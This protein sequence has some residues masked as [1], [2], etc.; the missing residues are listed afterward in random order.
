MNQVTDFSCENSPQDPESIQRPV[1]AES[2]NPCSL[3]LCLPVS[4]PTSLILCSVDGTVFVSDAL[5]PTVT[6]NYRDFSLAELGS[7]ILLCC[8]CPFLSPRSY[9]LQSP[10]PPH[11]SVSKS[12]T[13]LSGQFTLKDAAATC[14]QAGTYTPLPVLR[15]S[16]IELLSYV[17]HLFPWCSSTKN[18]LLQPVGW[19]PGSPPITQ[20]TSYAC[21]FLLCLLKTT[22]FSTA[23]SFYPIPW[24]LITHSHFRLLEASLQFYYKLFKSEVPEG[25]C[26]FSPLFSLIFPFALRQGWT[27]GS[28]QT[29]IN[30]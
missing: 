23:K 15:C 20:L 18:P 14:L 4:R 12:R 10:Q 3:V 21:H 9:L 11:F 6:R 5:F 19:C 13:P 28:Y 17:L 30:T 16:R 26:T 27:H 2:T 1:Q 24:Y 22:I 8:S 29:I 25:S 7:F